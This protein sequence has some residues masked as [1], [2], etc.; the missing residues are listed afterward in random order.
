MVLTDKCKEDFL[1][2][3]Y[4]QEDTNQASDESIKEKLFYHS[5]KWIE[6]QDE[7]LI[8]ALIIEFFDSVGIYIEIQKQTRNYEGENIVYFLS[9]I[10]E[11]NIKDVNN[12]YLFLTRQ[13]STEEAI[14][15]ANEIYNNK[16]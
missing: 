12:D 6:R 7:R 10:E 3:V 9:F 15:K 4:Y 11:E 8:N 16:N 1:I 14:K 2:K 5:Q 13:E